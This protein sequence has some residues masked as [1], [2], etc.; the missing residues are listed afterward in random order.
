MPIIIY[1]MNVIGNPLEAR[2]MDEDN[3][4]KIISG[5][6]QNTLLDYFFATGPEHATQK[7]PT[8]E[9]Q[10]FYNKHYSVVR[11]SNSDHYPIVFDMIPSTIKYK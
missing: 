9:K 1:I 2:M 5:Q 6:N 10:G 3:P 4:I 11:N 7:R 8:P